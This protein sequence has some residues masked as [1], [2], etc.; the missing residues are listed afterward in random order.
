LPQR[1]KEDNSVKNHYNIDGFLDF[2]ST[3]HFGSLCSLII[4]KIS[5]KVTRQMAGDFAS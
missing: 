5:C 2:Q 3:E 1:Q 4:Y